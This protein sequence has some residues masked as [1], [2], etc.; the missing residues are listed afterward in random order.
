M[1]LI[2]TKKAATPA[3]SK[4]LQSL[5]KQVSI[6]NMIH[7]ELAGWEKARPHGTIHASELFKDMEFCPREWAFLD[8][9]LAKKK[10]SF[11]GTA[12]KIT[13]DHGR[14]MEN[15]LRNEWI[16]DYMVGYWECNVCG[17]LHP[18]F[19]KAPK[20][21]CPKCGWGNKWR[22]H[23]VRVLDPKSGVSGGIDGFVDVGESKLRLLEIKSMDKDMHKALKAPLADHKVRTSLYLKL[24]ELA[25]EEYT[26][27]INTQESTVLYVSK[28]YGFKD[29]TLAASGIKDSPFSPFK[30]YPVGRNDG[31]HKLELSKATALTKWRALNDSG[32][33]PGLPCGVCTNG[34]S[35]RAQQCSSIAPCFS[36]GFPSTITWTDGGVPKHPGKAIIAE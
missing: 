28:S 27:R 29:D 23:E 3:P 22:Y 33:S 13:F 31:L 4:M 7:K 25:H 2:L 11:L 21:K 30:E 14:D 35:K 24:V 8:L 10:D 16:R 5:K 1:A 36:G 19:G 18:T 15:R 34:L 20:I 9:G 12:M 26:D 6:K 17:H 32:G